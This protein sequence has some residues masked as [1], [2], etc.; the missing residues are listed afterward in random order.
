MGEYDRIRLLVVFDE[1][2]TLIEENYY[3]SLRWVL[4]KVIQPAWE[5]GWAK[6]PLV[7][8]MP[9]MAIF[10][11]TNSKVA[12][13]TPPGAQASYRYYT[14]AMNVPRPFTALAWDV[15]V[16]NPVRLRRRQTGRRSGTN[17]PASLRYQD[18]ATMDWLCRFGRPVWYA[19]WRSMFDDTDEA[20]SIEKDRIIHLAQKKLCVLKDERDNDLRGLMLDNNDGRK[21]LTEEA[22]QAASAVLSVLVGIDFDFA[23]PDR[24]TELVASRL[25][26]AIAS[27]D[28]LTRFLTTYP[29]EPIL[30]EAAHQFF[31]NKIIPGS[32]RKVSNGIL[33]VVLKEIEH[34]NYD[35]GSDGELTARILCNTPFSTELTGRFDG[36]AKVNSRGSK[37]TARSQRPRPYFG[38]PSFD[39]S[40]IVPSRA[41]Q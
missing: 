8:P 20:R 9:F 39:H 25:R 22:I 2:N 31:F 37:A 6:Y 30:A 24:A 12:D 7:R 14:G 27:N 18:L 29:S 35:F 11:G 3:N 10:L 38:K 34:G 36:T 17:P 32:S 16:A 5:T 21:E 13:F 19:R 23:C 26:W 28:S 4:D 1:A 41:I 40:R 15:H 33:N